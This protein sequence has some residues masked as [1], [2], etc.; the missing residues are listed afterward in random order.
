MGA[1]IGYKNVDTLVRALAFLPGYELRLMSRVPPGERERLQALAPTARLTFADGAS[2][3]E[4]REALLRATALVSASRDEGFGI[5]LVEA[6]TAGTPLVVS[7]IPIFREVGGDAALYAPVDDPSAFAAA[8]RSLEDPEE[9]A[10]RSAAVT[11][12]ARQFS[13]DASAARLLPLLLELAE[14]RRR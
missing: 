6:M 3:E 14:K 8:V 4:Y 2:D 5:P 7:D 1:F 10:A 13:W 11:A 9:W 12:R